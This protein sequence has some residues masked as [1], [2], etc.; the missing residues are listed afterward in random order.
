MPRAPF[1]GPVVLPNVGL[2]G[3]PLQKYLAE[4]FKKGQIPFS[5]L[6][7]IEVGRMLAQAVIEDFD[8]TRSS[9]QNANR[10]GLGAL[11]AFVKDD[12]PPLGQN[13]INELPPGR[14]RSQS[15]APGD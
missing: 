11:F 6:S 12:T 8:R 7:P 15:V 1:A 13:P 3:S 9:L 14:G 4:R 2:V 10:W 5:N